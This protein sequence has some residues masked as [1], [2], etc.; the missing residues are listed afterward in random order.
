MLDEAKNKLISQV[1]PGTPMGALMRRYWHPIAGASEFDDKIRVR[2]IRLLGE[3]LVLYKDL[4]GTYGLVDRHCAHRRADLSYGFVEQCGLRCNY[5][6]WLYDEK[7]KCLAQPYE[8]VA[9]PNAN[10]KER[11]RL[12]AYKVQ[13]HAGMVWAYLGPE[14]APLVPNW[15]PFTWKNGFVQIVL[16]TIPCNWFQCQENSIDPVHFE[17]MHLNWSK[18]LHNQLGPYAPRHMK[19]DFEEF[20]YGIKYKRITEITDDKD[21]LWTIGRVCLWPNA[22]YTGEHFEWRVPIDDDNTFSITWSFVRVPK[23]RE[24]YVQN[25]IPTWKGPIKDEATGR[26]IDTHVMNQDFIAWVGQGTVA[27]RTKENLASSDKGIALQRRQFFSDL[28]AIKEGKDPKGLVRDP[29]INQCVPLP[30]AFKDNYVNGLTAAEMLKHPV[31]SGQLK[32]YVFQIGQPEEVRRA[33]VDAMGIDLKAD[34]EIPTADFLARGNEQ[35]AGT[36]Q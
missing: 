18:R 1:G 17:W 23:E 21:P 5:H 8:D 6:G 4:S 15:E 2:P 34:G 26:W 3:D 35:Q 9:L 14:P 25:R 11:I 33:F 31:F 10:T 32:G 36:T 12:K 22:L 7:G 20:E 27:D 16:A 29:K 24:P 13:E 30:I 19:V 28:E